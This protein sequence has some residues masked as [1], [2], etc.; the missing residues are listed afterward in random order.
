MIEV[1]ARNYKQHVERYLNG[2][3]HTLLQDKSVTH[4]L[5][6]IIYSLV[7]TPL[8]E[9]MDLGTFY[10]TRSAAEVLKALY[11]LS[12]KR[13]AIGMKTG[14]QQDYDLIRLYAKSPAV[15]DKDGNCFARGRYAGLG[16]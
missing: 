13:A 8:E 3:R 14:S 2:F 12:P 10:A 11:N 5:G 9:C 4:L 15:G 6:G 1:E 7:G 16:G